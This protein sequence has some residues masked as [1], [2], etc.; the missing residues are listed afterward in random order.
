MDRTF[1]DGENKSPMLLMTFLGCLGKE[2]KVF[3][4]YEWSSRDDCNLAL[5]E[6]NLGGG[7]IHQRKLFT[8][9]LQN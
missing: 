6:V 3:R 1:K 8:F 4:K 9:F 5:P 2:E 7:T